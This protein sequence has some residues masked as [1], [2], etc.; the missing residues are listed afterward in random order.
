[1]SKIVIR[2]NVVVLPS[3]RQSIAGPSKLPNR[4]V[5]V[6]KTWLTFPTH[7]KIVVLL[8]IWC[9]CVLLVM[10]PLGLSCVAHL[11]NTAKRSPLPP[12]KSARAWFRMVHDQYVS[13]TGDPCIKVLNHSLHC[14]LSFVF[15]WP[16]KRDQGQN[17]VLGYETSKSFWLT[18][19]Q[20]EWENLNLKA[21]KGCSV[22]F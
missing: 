3:R 21:V 14:F 18:V 11:S 6:A 20:Y 12:R 4:V 9:P 15:F 2:V 10:Q 8:C 17:S 7:L 1:M 5:F 19:F 22:W 13:S 16:M